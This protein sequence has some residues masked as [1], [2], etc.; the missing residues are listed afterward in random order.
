MSHPYILGVRRRHL[1]GALGI[2]VAWLLASSAE[3]AISQFYTATGQV[4]LSA[5]GAGSTSATYNIRA[6]KPSATATVRNAFLMAATV[7]GGT[8]ITN[9]DIQLAGNNVTF[10]SNVPCSFGCTS[11]LGEVTTIVKPT[12]DAAAAG[13]TT[14]TVSEGA[15]TGG[16]DGTALVVVWNDPAQIQTR[17]VILL[18]GSQATAGDTFAIT[19]ASPIDPVAAGATLDMGLGISFSFQTGGS[20]QF[21]IVKVNGQQVTTSAGGE[22]DGQPADGALITVGG[23]GD[24]NANPNPTALP[25]NPRSDDELYSLLP[26]ITN[27]TTSISVFTQNPS[28]NDNIFLAYFNISGSAIVGEGIVLGPATATNA[29]G[30]SHTVTATVVDAAGAPVVGKT[31]TF[32]IT[33]GPNSPG[34]GTAVTDATG[35]ATFTYTSNGTPGTDQIQASFVNS[36]QQTVTSNVVTKIWEGA[37]GPTPTP[38]PNVV[39][40]TLD[41][42]GLG[43]FAL[44]L[45]GVGLLLVTGMLKR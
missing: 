21:S 10:T 6:N 9:T 18:F 17:T 7:P 34:T 13:I 11:Y 23:I 25:T 33:S 45:A 8:T 32:T 15:K 38:T 41:S 30:T 24:T 40:P 42:K 12:L 19:L 4:T 5:D 28:N 26:F 43:L 27:T 16:I 44:L 20:Q 39:I 31:V 14:F 37:I 3:A 2:V 29:V 36:Q 1:L 35:K 22:D